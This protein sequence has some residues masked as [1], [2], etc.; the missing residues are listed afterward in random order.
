M[1]A[2]FIFCLKI[3][4][5][6]IFNILKLL[7]LKKIKVKLKIKKNKLKRYLKISFFS[8]LMWLRNLILT[9]FFSFTQKK[10][11]SSHFTFD[12][13]FLEFCSIEVKLIERIID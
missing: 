7:F 1:S 9:L 2:G 11:F 5:Y 12:Q 10:N 6:Q 4:Y 8:C 3:S 13:H